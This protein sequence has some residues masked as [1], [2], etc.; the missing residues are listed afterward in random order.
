MSEQARWR[1]FTHEELYRMLHDGPGAA[2]SA[3]PSRRWAE[4]STVLDEI[5]HGLGAALTAAGAAWVGRAAGAAHE[6][7]SPMATWASATSEHAAEMRV[8]VENQG[9]H[10]ARAR[11][12]MPAPSET[13]AVAPDP[14]APPAAQVAGGATDLEAAEAASSAGEQRAVE[15]MAAYELSTTQNLAG[16]TAFAVPGEVRREGSVHRGRGEGVRHGTQ[17]SSVDSHG[18]SDHG[19]HRSHGHGG[20]HGG[21]HVRES[22]GVNFGHTA[23][24]S[25]SPAIAPRPQPQPMA[26]GI[27]SGAAAV[28]QGVFGAPMALGA[29]VPRSDDRDRARRAPATPA[30]GNSAGHSGGS[31]DAGDRLGHNNS[32]AATGPVP[33]GTPMAPGHATGAPVGAAGAGGQ[34]DKLAMRRFGAEA[35]GSSQWFADSGDA[36]PVRSVSGRRR[37]LGSTENMTENVTVDGEDHL[38]PP[39]VIGG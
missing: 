35:I 34:A 31:V 30:A 16:L 39:P 18:R 10:I 12:D 22:G 5:G 24:S 38:L 17:L 25:A 11:A 14:A 21:V 19:G 3:G 8:V 7:L 9:D 28:S 37:D 27:Q 36:T 15:V 29:P 33:P 1:G 6:R 20:P 2:A 23:G 4:L 32:Q 13:P 26:P